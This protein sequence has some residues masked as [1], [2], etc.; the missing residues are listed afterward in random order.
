ML[1]HVALGLRG[2][3][4]DHEDGDDDGRGRRERDRELEDRGASPRHDDAPA[5]ARGLG[6][7]AGLEARRRL[8]RP[9]DRVGTLG[10]ARD[11]RL[12]P[13]LERPVE[14]AVD[15]PAEE[16]RAGTGEDEEPPPESALLARPLGAL[17]AIA[18]VSLDAARPLLREGT[19]EVLRELQRGVVVHF[20][21]SHN[22]ERRIRAKPDSL[23]KKG[24]FPSFFLSLSFAL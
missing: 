16:V 12:D 24:R 15:V 19:V 4:H 5:A 3:T 17:R 20:P 2:L 21:R 13:C 9:R 23:S 8:A 1:G 7:L 22:D 10:A 18:E 6:E 11:V 14:R